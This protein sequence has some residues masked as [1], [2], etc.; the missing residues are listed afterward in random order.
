M[1][2]VCAQSSQI[3]YNIQNILYDI[4]FFL[5]TLFP[6]SQNPPFHLSCFTGIKSLQQKSVESWMSVLPCPAGVTPHY[7]QGRRQRPL[8]GVWIIVLSCFMMLASIKTTN[9]INE[10]VQN[11]NTKKASAFMHQDHLQ[12][13]SV[14]THINTPSH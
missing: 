8:I 13:I 9:G 4:P 11:S 6:C 10:P 5:F 12:H 14:Q 1:H 7:I 3:V 2:D